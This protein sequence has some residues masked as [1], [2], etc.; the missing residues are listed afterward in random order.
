MHQHYSPAGFRHGERQERE[1]QLLH[2]TA[3][4]HLPPHPSHLQ[5]IHGRSPCSRRTRV[6]R[7]KLLS[8]RPHLR[9]H[10]S[11]RLGQ[12]S[13]LSPHPRNDNSADNTFRTQHSLLPRESP[14]HTQ[15]SPHVPC[16]LH[17]RHQR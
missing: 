16:K 7:L 6:S 3:Q 15:S 17:Q 9:L 5:H 13:K 11:R 14:R 1:R 2:A 8:E 10:A 4:P 12:F